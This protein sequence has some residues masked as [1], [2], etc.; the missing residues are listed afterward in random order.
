MTP[1][2]SVAFLVGW[3]AVFGATLM[4]VYRIRKEGR[5][6]KVTELRVAECTFVGCE[7]QMLITINEDDG[8]SEIRGYAIM[9]LDVFER[10][11]AAAD[12]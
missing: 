10:L 2:W 5:W 6:R 3:G 7:P 9:P 11:E 4:H 1:L 12:R 8:C